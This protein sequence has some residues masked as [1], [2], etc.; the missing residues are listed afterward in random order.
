[1]FIENRVDLG[2]GIV[3]DKSYWSYYSILNILRDFGLVS[4]DSE[5]VFELNNFEKFVF[6]MLRL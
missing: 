3:T 1:M 6:E 4:Q 2:Q 5:F